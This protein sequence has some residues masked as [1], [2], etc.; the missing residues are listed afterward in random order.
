MTRLQTLRH[1]ASYISVLSICR[2]SSQTAFVVL[3]VV[4]LRKEVEKKDEKK[5]EEDEEIVDTEV[6]EKPP[7][8]VTM[9]KESDLR[10]RIPGRRE[11][12]PVLLPKT[13]L[14]RVWDVHLD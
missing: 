12:R 1:E 10:P 3:F 4:V 14:G 5:D 13:G 2:E 8:V 7:P 6:V 9:E 11:V